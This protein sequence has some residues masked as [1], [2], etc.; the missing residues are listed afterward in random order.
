MADLEITEKRRIESL[1]NSERQTL[2]EKF[3]SVI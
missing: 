2:L 3:E 1:T